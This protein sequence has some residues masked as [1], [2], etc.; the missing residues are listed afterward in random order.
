MS[1]IMAISWRLGLGRTESVDDYLGVW[2]PLEEAHLYSYSAREGRAKFDER[3]HM[4]DQDM[5]AQLDRVEN[6]ERDGEDEDDNAEGKDEDN[7]A[8]GML[9]R[10]TAEYTIEG[11]RAEMRKG[12]GGGPH[13]TWT[14]YESESSATIPS[15]IQRV[16]VSVANSPNS[17]IKTHE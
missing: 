7:E 3:D 11:L 16:A 8:Q 13:G 1:F 2:V 5:E 17:Q 4:M 10:R 12:R 6:E 14:T 15:G 9:A